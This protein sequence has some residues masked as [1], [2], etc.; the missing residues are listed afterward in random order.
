MNKI[1]IWAKT[2]KKNTNAAR[3][4]VFVVFALYA[5]TIV[6]GLVWTFFNSFKDSVEYILNPNKLPTKWYFKNYADAFNLLQANETGLFAMFFNSIWIT[7]VRSFVSISC[8]CCAGYVFSKCR[9]VGKKL[10]YNVL[11]FTMMLPLFGTGAAHMK[12]IHALKLYDSVLYP[13][14]ASMSMQGMMMLVVKTYFDGIS[15]EYAEAAKI[16]GA[17]HYTI[18]FKVMMPLAMP[19]LFSIFVL[20]I[21]EGWNDYTMSL[22]YMPGF[23]TLV[24]GLYLYEATAKFNIN[25]PVYFAGLMMASIP[26]LLGYILLSDKIL[27]NVA[28]GGI[29]G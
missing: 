12:L 3:V 19:C 6:Y 24:T 2:V 9:F 17:G 14:V 25:Y 23:S 16:D 29:K 13:V 22:Y 4:A 21:I 11:L 7:A 15:N 8:L 20:M 26:T 1:K 18:F 27:N 28:M 5:F 10:I